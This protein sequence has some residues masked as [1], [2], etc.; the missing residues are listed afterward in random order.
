MSKKPRAGA[1]KAIGNLVKWVEGSADWADDFETVMEDH[2][3]KVVELSG[4][5]RDEIIEMLGPEGYPVLF[6]CALEDLAS[7]GYEAEPY[8]L[9]DDYLKRRGWRETAQ[10][11]RYLE[12]L[13]DA[14]MSLYEVVDVQPGRSV[15]VRDLLRPGRVVRVSERMGSQRIAKWDRLATR[16]LADVDRHIFSGVLL[17]IPHDSADQLVET[18]QSAVAEMLAS[19]KPA[20]VREALTDSEIADIFLRGLTPVFTTYWLGELLRRRHHPIPEMVNFDGDPIQFCEVTFPL[21]DGAADQV[22]ERLATVAGFEPEGDGGNWAWL[23]E[24]HADKSAGETSQ[25]GTRSYGHLSL[26][27]DRL[28]LFTNSLQR[29]ERGKELLQ[30]ALEGLADAPLTGVKSVQQALAENA[31]GTAQGAALPPEEEAQVIGEFFQ[32]H[33][34]AWLDQ[35]IPALDRQ[36]PRQAVGTAAGRKKVTA[37]LK[38]IENNED[39]R[40]RA[41][42]APPF[43]F[44]WLWAELGLSRDD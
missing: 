3:A 20:A 27:G 41:K 14:T 28:V 5:D 4:L 37:L 2:L 6:G 19:E 21:H 26:Q 29:A 12:A 33:Y 40:S 34:R 13:R 22:G 17:P 39:R 25:G 30:S 16:V 36:T 8:N 1:D 42:G 23:G 31:G 32:R 11:R 24:E 9:V 18:V 44:E 38:D 15:E 43:D 35:E 7:R 10:G